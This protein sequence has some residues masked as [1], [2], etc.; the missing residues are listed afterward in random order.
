MTLEEFCAYAENF[1]REHGEPGTLSFRHLQRL[2]A[3]KGPKGQPL[4]PIRPATARLLERIFETDSRE[5][6]APPMQAIAPPDDAELRDRIKKSRRVDAGMLKGLCDQ[7]STIR[8]I[9]RQYGAIVT[10]NELLS[11]ISQVRNLFVYSLSGDTR[12]ELAILLSEMHA[13]AGWQSLDMG[14]CSVSWHHYEQAKMFALEAKDTSYRVHAVAEQAF[15][16]VEMGEIGSAVELIESTRQM[17]KRFCSQLLC[18]WN[19]AA[20]GEVL[21]AAGEASFALKQFDEAENRLPSD[22]L[23]SCGP[24]VVLDM[25]HLTRWRGSSSVRLGVPSSLGLL[26]EA[27]GGLDPSFSRAES[28]LRVDLASALA[29]VGDLASAQDQ[30]HIG[31]RIATSVGSQRQLNKARRFEK[32][33]GS[34]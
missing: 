25:N 30:M 1:A 7:L 34:R 16:L 20:C 27:I 8:R 28:A 9:D 13:L 24:Y 31:I 19:H 32:M 10:H 15:T 12:R 17:A 33:L 14:D 29:G 4:G 5:L 6:L 3:G 22:T 23:V 26:T 11:K 18:S 2:V 21:A